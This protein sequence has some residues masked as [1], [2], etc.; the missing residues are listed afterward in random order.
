MATIG[1]TTYIV[2]GYDGLA[3]DPVVLATND[4]RRVP[5]CG[6]LRCRRAIQRSLR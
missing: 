2:G 4:G 6:S 1:S 5:S 3:S